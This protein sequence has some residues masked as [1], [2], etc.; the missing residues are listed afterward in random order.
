MGIT[1][2]PALWLGLIAAAIAC[3]GVVVLALPGGSGAQR[4]APEETL[5]AP[6]A[7]LAQALGTSSPK[8]VSESPYAI[9]NATVEDLLAGVID[10]RQRQDRAWL[11]RTLESTS[12]KAELSEEDWHTAHRQFV[13]G[14]VSRLWTRVS[15][16]WNAREY[17][18][19]YEGNSARASFHVGGAL[20]DLWFDFVRIGDAWYFRGI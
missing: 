9:T 3:A 12:G 2:K 8:S 16:A 6:Q 4:A 17:T 15:E 11:A 14:S 18:V 19:S 20:G 7:E 5:P 13:W 1:W 10:A